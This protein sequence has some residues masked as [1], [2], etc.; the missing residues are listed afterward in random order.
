MNRAVI[1][2]KPDPLGMEFADI[3][4]HRDHLS[5]AGVAIG[6]APVPYRLEYE[7]ETSAGFLTTRLRVSAIGQGWS[8]DL[9][10]RRDPAG[11]WTA[12]TGM[13]G[14]VDLPAPGG[15]V[16]APERALD[17]DLALSPLTNSMP[18]L[19]HR[20]QAGGASHDF[21]MAFVSVPDL[22]VRASRQRYVFVRRDDELAV[23]RYESMDSDFR[24]DLTVDWHGLVVDYPGIG[25]LISS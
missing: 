22:G 24:A 3:A 21:Q 23:I 17:C 5:A 13:K 8:R 18:I 9:D 2:A 11:S 6:S 7:L 1:W 15:I 20:L 16:G 4:F 12:L 19:R 10:L 25:R 14:E